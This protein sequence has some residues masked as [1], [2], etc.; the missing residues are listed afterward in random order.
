MYPTQQLEVE[1]YSDYTV[2]VALG[3]CLFGYLEVE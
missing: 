3:M 2:D 1:L